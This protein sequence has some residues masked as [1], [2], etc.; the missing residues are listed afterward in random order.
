MNCWSWGEAQQ[1]PADPKRPKCSRGG[2]GTDAIRHGAMADRAGS[3]LK[4]ATGQQVLV[5]PL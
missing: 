2:L 3:D 1:W 4:S 5:E